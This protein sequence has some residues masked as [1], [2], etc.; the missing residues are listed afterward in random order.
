MRK[1]ILL[2]LCLIWLLPG[3]IA[4]AA[5]P[6][7]D[8]CEIFPADNPWNVDISGATPLGNSTQIIN[9]INAH[10][11]DNIHP[12]FGDDQE[13]GIPWITVDSTQA[14]VPVTFDYDDESDP[15]PYPFPTNAPIEAG[16]D[17]HVLVIERDNCV[18]YETW[19]SNYVGGAQH[20]WTAGSGAIWNLNSN[21]LRPDG[22]TSA[23]A[24]GLPIFPGL[25]RCDEAMSGTINHAFRFT[26]GTTKDGSYIYPATHEAGDSN[27]PNAPVIGM[28]FRLK[29]TFNISN[30]A[31]Q[32]KAIAQALKTYGMI[33]ADNGSNWYISGERDRNE[34]WHDD[35]DDEGDRDLEDLKSIPGNQFEVVSGPTEASVDFTL[36]TPSLYQPADGA[37][38]T[39][40]QPTLGWNTITSATS[41][42][43]QIGRDNPPTSGVITID[44]TEYTQYTPPTPL[45]A[46]FTYF[47]RVR[48]KAPGNVTTAWSDVRSVTIAQA[49]GAAPI[50]NFYTDTTPTLTWSAVTGQT[51]Y[52]VQ[53][54]RNTSF[55][56][57]IVDT[58]GA[59]GQLS[60]TT[61]TLTTGVYYWRVRAESSATTFGQWTLMETF[62]VDAG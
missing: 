31:P 48:A 7:V 49:A 37:A 38:I 6:T 40:T 41:Y 3:M 36:P 11:G 22:W 62:T 27:D 5:P 42:E 53:V 28:R 17:R 47:W 55:S 20:A 9:F 58:W 10:G 15:G 60:V 25:A 45:L 32:S 34:C 21:A 4:Q 46:G 51:R 14:K 52:R 33:L 35:A 2:A 13:Y 57:N 50:R 8:G 43:F 59:V 44:S 39:S 18:L 23:D 54:S 29:S 26:V 56:P 16:G 19:D 30:F 12:D 1:L 61:S 24:G